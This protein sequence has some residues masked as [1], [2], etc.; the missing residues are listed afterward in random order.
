L[1]RHA[2]RLLPALILTCFG[3]AALTATHQ[4]SAGGQTIKATN[5]NP[6]DG[7]LARQIRHYRRQTW[8][9]QS[10]MGVGRTRANRAVVHHPSRAYKRWV[11]N[12][13]KRRAIRVRRKA[14]N[15][16]HKTG[17]LCIHRY[18]GAWNDPNAPYYGGLQMDIGF[19]R[20]YGAH[21]L[22]KKGT[23]DNWT[24]LEQMWVAEKAHRS[25]RGYYPWPNTARHC[26]LI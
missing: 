6:A 19:Q 7:G 24:P 10:V 18:E 4:A 22:R 25:G 5:V 2:L 9:W 8:R 23:A 26:G 12:L 20:T 3:L 13:W 16:P 17:W 21:L 11:R 15:P 1:H 14:Q